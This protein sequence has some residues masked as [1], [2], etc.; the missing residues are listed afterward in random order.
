M[1]ESMTVTSVIY[2]RCSWWSAVGTEQGDLSGKL[3]LEA[4]PQ[5]RTRA[6]GGD[7]KRSWIEESIRPDRGSLALFGV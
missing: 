1:A 6:S 4:L 7:N 5:S 2:D 3:V